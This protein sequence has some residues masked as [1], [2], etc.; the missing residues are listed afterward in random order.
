MGKRGPKP[1]PTKI[2]ALRG[3]WRAKTRPN[4]P[5]PPAGEPAMPSWLSRSAKATWKSVV[6]PL[7]QMGVASSVDR[8]ALAR[9]CETLVTWREARKT[10]DVPA[11]VKLS[12]ILSGLESSFGMTPASRA[13]LGA[14]HVP[15]PSTGPDKSRFFPDRA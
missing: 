6:P 9:Y 13:E 2:L 15:E 3:S 8:F 5:I 11:M 1:T 14:A 10:H 12:N 7:V 4:E